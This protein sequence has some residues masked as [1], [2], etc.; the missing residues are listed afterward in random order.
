MESGEN[1]RIYV[2]DSV[3]L[4]NR[5]WILRFLRMRFCEIVES[6]GGFEPLKER[7]L[8]FWQKPKVAKAFLRFCE[9]ESRADSMELHF[10]CEILRK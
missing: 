4:Q 7:R 1:H 8:Y 9:A 5:G 10:V 3:V 2:A 6:L